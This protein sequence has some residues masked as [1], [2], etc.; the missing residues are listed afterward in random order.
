MKKKNKKYPH[1]KELFHT[2]RNAYMNEWRKLNPSKQ[3]IKDEWRK[4]DDYTYTELP[5]DAIP[6]PNY[7]TYYVQPDGNIWRDTRGT[8]TAIKT[9]KE[10]VL[11]LRPTYTPQNGYWIIQPYKDNK[12]KAI[13]LHRFV[14]TAFK[15]SAPEDKME[16]HHINHNTSDN[17]INNL[18]W[19]TR[20]ENV[21]FVPKHHRTVLKKTYGT[22]RELS[23]TKWSPMYP[24]IKELLDSGISSSDISESLNMPKGLI[25]SIIK[26]IERRN[27]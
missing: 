14:L 27:N 13:Y 7:P 20:Q 11:K 19:V 6:V 5:S 16:C 3:P 12:K 24:K 15:G 4:L 17:S 10:R 9:G 1:L 8:P 26:S 21:D 18:M 2:D 22:G 23:N 25:Y